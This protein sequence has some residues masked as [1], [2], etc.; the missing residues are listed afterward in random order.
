MKKWI[1]IAITAFILTCFAGCGEKENRTDAVVTPKGEVSDIFEIVEERNVEISDTEEGH[2]KQFNFETIDATEYAKYNASNRSRSP[3]VQDDQQS[4]FCI[5]ADTGAVYFV[6]QEKDWYIYCM[7]NGKVELAV[8]LPAKELYMWDGTLYF[9]I[10]DY[11]IYQWKEGKENDIYAYTP[12]DGSVVFI[13]TVEELQDA[14]DD[15]QLGV[16]EKGIY[17]AYEIRGED[18]IING[19]KGY[20]TNKFFIMLPHGSKEWVEDPFRRAISGWGEYFLMNGSIFQSR[21]PENP[22]QFKLDVPASQSCII[23]DTF[24]SVNTFGM[25][26]YITD[27]ISGESKSYDCTPVLEDVVL[28]GLTGPV[29]E[30]YKGSIQR[31]QSFA[32]T[33]EYVWILFQ[34]SYLVRVEPET[35]EMKC[36]V[37]GETIK[38]KE[39]ADSKNKKNVAYGYMDKLYTDGVN[40]YAL[41]S[42]DAYRTSQELVKIEAEH[43]IE[44]ARSYK[45]PT[46][47]VEKLFQ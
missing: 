6:N 4:L 42:A 33:K 11:D 2:G 24:Y 30:E 23:D 22:V 12:S 44:G 41:Y 36:F 16:D 1:T 29:S 34:S 27:L 14:L 31:I 28:G 3:S 5:D 45:V 10:E 47:E 17:L 15:I 19:R 46:I 26:L 39:S 13:D 21:N 25:S 37:T 40:L 43:I 8:D 20:K 7:Q 35:G 32:V 38:T 18:I 9:M